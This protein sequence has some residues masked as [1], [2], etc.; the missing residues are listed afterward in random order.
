MCNFGLI[1]KTSLYVKNL[2]VRCRQQITETVG[3]RRHW[4]TVLLAVALVSC[5]T[6]VLPGG[7][8]TGSTTARAAVVIGAVTQV[9]PLIVNGITIDTANAVTTIE[10]QDD[11]G[12]GLSVGMIVRVDGSAADTATTPTQVT[13]EKISSGAELRGVVDEVNTG[14]NFVK[15]LGVAVSAASTTVYDNGFANL[16]SLQTGDAIQVHGYPLPDGVVFATRVT[17]TNATSIIKLTGGVS[18]AS[19]PLCL[20]AS[21]DF[22]LGSLTV[23]VAGSE[24]V[25]VSLPLTNGAL[26]KV[27]GSLA[28]T[29]GVL[30]ATQIAR[31]G[32]ALPSEKS[33]V[34][35]RS[36]F[37]GDATAASYSL[38]GLPT[39][40]TKDTQI[41]LLPRT[42]AAP[43]LFPGI[44]LE[45]T[46]NISDGALVA[47]QIKEIER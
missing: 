19:C 33:F 45:V 12:R 17:K 2:L 38:A 39:R 13:A 7:G 14:A 15:A 36:A 20:P 30:N 25:N 24:L 28:G 5:G 4:F 8:G 31:Y 47:T 9:S 23:R 18:G 27:T 26:V 3:L 42:T 40:T 46:G 16:N 6:T 37:V 44:I 22:L 29:P 11:A 32:G 10:T 35:I 34:S 1:A 43:S 21:N 41:S